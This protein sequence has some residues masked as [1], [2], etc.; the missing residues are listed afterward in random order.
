MAD[1]HPVCRP[2]RN[3]VDNDNDNAPSRIAVNA[4]LVFIVFLPG[5]MAPPR[6]FIRH[7]SAQNTNLE[8]QAVSVHFGLQPGYRR[9]AQSPGLAGKLSQHEIKVIED[10]GQCR[11]VNLHRALPAAAIRRQKIPGFLP[12]RRHRGR[13]A[14]IGV[15]QFNQQAFRS[16][17]MVAQNHE[18]NLLLDLRIISRD[19]RLSLLPVAACQECPRN[20]KSA[21]RSITDSLPQA[22]ARPKPSRR[23]VRGERVRKRSPHLF[24]VQRGAGRRFRDL[25][26]GEIV[27]QRRIGFRAFS[28]FFK[29]ASNLRIALAVV[30]L[31][32]LFFA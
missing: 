17:Q 10:G 16:V 24:A 29:V 19:W 8:E 7:P 28:A 22:R 13:A 11:I 2:L 30:L 26:L 14:R 27:S 3:E 31:D 9:L 5:G 32:L 23:A 18:H 6:S 21:G 4:R 20:E 25:Q 12:Q 15:F 1:L